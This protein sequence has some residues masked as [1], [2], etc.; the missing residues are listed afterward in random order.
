MQLVLNTPGSYLHVKDDIFE[1]RINEK[2][3]HIAPQKIRTIL[4][5]TSIAFS[6]NALRLALEHNIDVVFL[7][8][9]GKPFGRVWH[10]KLGSTAR[11]RRKQLEL[12][13]SSQG[14]EIGKQFIFQKW[15]NQINFLKEIRKQKTRLSSN[16]TT[17]MHQLQETTKKLQLIQGEIETCR[18]EIMG[19]EGNMARKYWALF[20]KLLPKEFVFIGR[21][22]NPAKDPFN[23]LLN[24]AYGV[25][26]SEVERAC[27]IAGI[28]PYIGF[29]HSDHYS[30]I[31]MVLDII[32]G[33][34]IFA[35]E[36]IY[37]FF[38]QR[39]VSLELFTQ[40]P[41]GLYLNKA[42]KEKL[43]LHYN[44]F[45]DARILYK[46]KRISRRHCIQKDLH[47]LANSWL[48]HT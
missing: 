48:K 14:T 15:N 7:R 28:D 30:K 36:A 11:I 46:G 1:I 20:S 41:E 9:S 29:I 47:Q 38:R 12:S 6:T 23:C 18:F 45:L 34:R 21:S 8:S 16:I 10:D 13:L 39:K 19:L 26:Y 22:R 42:G 43:L 44:E 40:I 27:I 17:V 2:K 3:T 32:E 37:L 31:S 24:Y 25:L 4:A 33:Y 35:E 5:T